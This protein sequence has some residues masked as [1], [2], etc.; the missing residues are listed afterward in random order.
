MNEF[1]EDLED[2]SVGDAE[3][4]IPAL[5]TTL[6]FYVSLAHLRPAQKLIFQLKS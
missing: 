6:D 2:W 4:A 1:R 5:Y 3:S